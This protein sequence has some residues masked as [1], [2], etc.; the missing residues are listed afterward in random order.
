MNKKILILGA[1]LE[2]SL[3]IKEAKKLNYFVIACD[4]NPNAFG[5]QFSDIS[6]VIDINNV[7]EIYSIGLKHEVNGIFTHAVEIPH[8][9]SKVAEKLNLPSLSFEKAE[10]ATN[11]SKRIERLTK[12]NIPCA[13]YIHVKNENNLFNSAY[14]IGFP[15]VIKPI[16]N[17]GSRGVCLVEKDRD[18]KTAFDEAVRFSKIKEVLLEE[19]LIGPEISTESIVYKGKIHTFAFADRNYNKKELFKPFFIED[20]INFPSN[21]SEEL[22]TE[23]LELVEKTIKCLEIDFG[24]AKGDIIIDK[25]KP[26]IIEMASRTSGGWFGAGSIYFATGAN[27][28]EPLIQMAMGD[29]PNMKSFQIN[30]NLGCAQRYI[31]PQVEGIVESIDGIENIEKMPGVEMSVLFLPKIGEKIK[32]ATNHAERFGQVICTAKTRE[33][34]IRLCE[35]VIKKIKI[36]IK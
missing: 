21:I 6:Y 23:I 4:S 30:R 17:A 11:K 28:L 20:G 8:I 33:E 29:E 36:N 19:V 10:R 35:D 34:A 22:K 13:K 32:K 16:D 3:A 1:G 27:M 25:G 2:Q 9:V 7:D 15:L 31:I 24:A 5:F 18:L 12:C 14:K 26:K